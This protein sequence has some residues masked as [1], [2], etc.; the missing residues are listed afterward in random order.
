MQAAFSMTEEGGALFPQG[1]AL[2]GIREAALHGMG[3]GW[4]DSPLHPRCAVLT[5][6]DFL[7]CGGVPGPSARHLLRRALMSER[8]EWLIDAP[9]GWMAPLEAIAKVS[10]ITRYAFDPEIQPENAPLAARVERLPEG[11]ALQPLE[12][13]WLSA[14]R[15]EAWSRDFVSQYTDEDYARRGLGVLLTL[16]G[17][18]VAGASSYLSY[19]GGIEVQVQTREGFER[20]GYATLASAGLILRAHE[21]GLR[22]TWDAAN[23]A[24]VRLA[25]KLGYRSAGAYTVAVFQGFWDSFGRG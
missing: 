3:R 13:A 2:H 8:R 17:R 25:E 19:P 14:C 7:L 20:R 11:A 21:R 1:P 24:S 9:E 18:A 15:Q 4:M 22:A 5:A 6:G 12:G 10:M 23:L 16:D